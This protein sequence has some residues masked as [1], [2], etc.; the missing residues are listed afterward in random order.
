MTEESLSSSFFVSSSILCVREAIFCYI[1]WFIVLFI[2]KMVSF[3]SF[4]HYSFYLLRD[5]MKFSNFFCW[6]FY[7]YFISDL[8]L[9]LKSSRSLFIELY[10]V[11]ILFTAT[12]IAFMF[13]LFSLL[14]TSFSSVISL[15]TISYI[16]WSVYFFP[17]ATSSFMFSS[18]WVSTSNYSV[19]R[20]VI[21][22]IYFLIILLT[23]F[24]IW[25]VT[26]STSY[27]CFLRSSCYP[28]H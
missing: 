17:F 18:S 15:F 11:S 5:S 28:F 10:I 22:C 25:P 4:V 9:A 23:F 3:I 13:A 26:F 19:M 6:L 21:S 12:S 7:N 14:S 24:L 2:V 16:F 1:L 20:L 8:V 27:I